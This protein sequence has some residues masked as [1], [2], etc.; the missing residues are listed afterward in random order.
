MYRQK[1]TARRPPWG[2][3]RLELKLPELL[4]FAI[5]RCLRAAGILLVVSL[6]SFALL[7]LAPGDYFDEFR[8][9]RGISAETFQFLRHQ[10]GLDQSMPARYGRWIR[11]CVDGTW[12]YSIAQHR[13]AGPLIRERAANTLLLSGTALMI[14]W[15]LAIPGAIW[16]MIGRQWRARLLIGCAS[17]VM[18]IPDLVL[19]LLLSVAALNTNLA[20]IA[21]MSSVGSEQLRGFNRMADV[22]LH[23][24]V[25][26]TTL[27]LS[28]LPVAVLHAINAMEDSMQEP[29][30][31][32]ARLNG[33]GRLRIL[34]RHVLPVAA[35]PLITL[36]G[37]SVGTLLSSAV[38]VEAVCG[39][40]GL[41]RLLLE[42]I[43]NRDMHVVLGATMLSCFFLLT[44]TSIA[45]MVLRLVDPRIRSSV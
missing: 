1:E 45:D 27:V 23:A 19:V 42:S 24:I 12:G 39:W 25:P 10:Y 7:D 5:H 35:N 26:I 8:L 9:N 34:V 29:F 4:M 21:G 13:P 6:L 33:V 28:M 32:T 37:V 31:L 14:T 40:P 11:A 22:A 20:P 30:V 3:N 36:A 17:A 41:G 15:L 44:A 2:S 18:S 16:A 43:Q 38:I